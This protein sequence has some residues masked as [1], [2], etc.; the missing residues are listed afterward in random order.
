MKNRYISL[1]TQRN[2]CS[3][4]TPM[5]WTLLLNSTFE[6]LKVVSW[7]KA[8]IMVM[9]GKVEVIEEYEKMIRGVRFAIK[10]PAVIRLNRFIKRKTPIVKFSRQ[11]LYI[12]D[13]GR[14]QYCG[15]SYEEKEL[16]YDHVIPR[17]RGGQTEWTN[18]V[19]CC[20]RCNLKKG[21]RT[22][23]EAGMFLIRRPRAPI[24]IPLLTMS[25]GIKETP[26]PWKNYLYLNPPLN[27]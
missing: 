15:A 1:K 12:R 7:K 16:T 24:W 11:N 17:S 23:E 6:P 19:T 18:I 27:S 5:E 3:T 10:L 2:F 9:L 22:P 21:G 26:E 25:L 8:I 20:I 13:G 4:L 14:C